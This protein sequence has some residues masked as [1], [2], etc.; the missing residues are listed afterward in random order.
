MQKFSCQEFNCLKFSYHEF[1][2]PALLF[3]GYLIYFHKSECDHYFIY[4]NPLI[5]SRFDPFFFFFSFQTQDLRKL[6]TD[7]PI[8]CAGD[9]VIEELENEP[10][11]EKSETELEIGNVHLYFV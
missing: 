9:Q 3:L 5:D 8:C 1:R 4:F 6:M 7:S 10:K 2:C 11:S